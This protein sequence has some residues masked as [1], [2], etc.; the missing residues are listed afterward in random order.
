MSGVCDVA[1]IGAGPYGLSLAAH[2]ADTGLDFRIFGK[3]LSTWREHMPKGMLL[4]SDGFASNISAPDPASTL[5]AYCRARGIAYEEQLLPVALSLFT[6]YSAWFQKRYVPQLEEKNVI[7]L[8][9]SSLGYRLTLEDGTAC[10]AASVVLAVGITWFAKTPNMLRALPPGMVSH[11]FDNHA[12]ERFTGRDVTVLGAGSSAIDTAALLADVGANVTLLA[13]SPALHFHGAPDPDGVTWLRQ[14]TYPSSGIGPGWRSFFCSRAPRLFRR[15]PENLRLEATRR[16]LGPAAGWFMRGRVEDRVTTL[17][18]TT[19]TEVS[20]RDGRVILQGR[21]AEDQ[22]IT[23][24]AH[25]VIAATGYKPDLR[26]LPFLANDIRGRLSQIAH[27]PHLSDNFE[28]SLPGL[29]AIGP[30]AAN[31][32]GPLMRFMVGAE[33]IAPR[34]SQHLRQA[35]RKR[36]AA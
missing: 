25:H 12:L 24:T 5:K 35:V 14:I 3:P 19:L 23:I 34:L 11:S 15:L 13:R 21:D 26:R 30:L 16:H 4:K 36:K 10:E 8:E 31:T 20:A 6:E 17:L 28:T 32:F 27:T 2:L 29:Y 7:S 33:Y 9:K 1:I 18:G 22:D